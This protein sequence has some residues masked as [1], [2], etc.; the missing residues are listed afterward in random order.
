MR[1]AGMAV[2]VGLPIFIL[3]RTLDY[4]NGINLRR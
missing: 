3:G 1:L 4:L 2:N